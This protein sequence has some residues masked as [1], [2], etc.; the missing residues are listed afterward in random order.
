MR[1]K[2]DVIA[3]QEQTG[4]VKGIVKQAVTRANAESYTELYHRQAHYPDCLLAMVETGDYPVGV[5]YV[6][7]DDEEE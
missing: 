4:L 2:Y 7:E 5:Q 1:K 6:R 3:Y